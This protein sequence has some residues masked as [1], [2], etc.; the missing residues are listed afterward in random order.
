MADEFN[1]RDWCARFEAAGGD[2]R[3]ALGNII[4]FW[5]SLSVQPEKAQEIAKEIRDVERAN[6]VWKEL[7]SRQGGVSTQG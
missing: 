5:P 6:A 3:A 7:V 1:A 2:V 4:N